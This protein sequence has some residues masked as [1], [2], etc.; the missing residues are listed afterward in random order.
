VRLRTWRK[1][2]RPFGKWHEGFR[3]PGSDLNSLLQWSGTRFDQW[4]LALNGLDSSN[5]ITVAQGDTV[6]A[7]ITLDRSFT[8]PAS[9]DTAWIQLSMYGTNFP[10]VDT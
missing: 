2:S 3:D 4:P 9:V 5:A 6:T 7:T 8:I 1:G 10:A